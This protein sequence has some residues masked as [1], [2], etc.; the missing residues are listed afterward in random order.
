MIKIKNIALLQLFGEGE[1][2][3]GA[4]P[5]AEGTTGASPAPAAEENI[6]AEDAFK[7]FIEKYGEDAEPLKKH[8]E[9]NFSKRYKAFKETE[10]KVQRLEDF[11]KKVA[12]RYPNAK[13]D[14]LDSLEEAFIGD[15]RYYRDRAY[16]E[17]KDA[18]EMAAEAVK[19]HRNAKRDKRLEEL[20]AANQ[21]EQAKKRME[22]NAK[23]FYDRLGEEEKEL[24]K[25]FADFNLEEELK[26]PR[27]KQMLVSGGLSLEEAYTVLHHADIVKKTAEDAKAA[28][29]SSIAS[30]GT[31]VKEG[32]SAATVP[33]TSAI[34]YQNM[35]DRDF[36]KLYNSMFN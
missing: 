7:S 19:D 25:K 26:N 3:A 33:S 34:D 23:Q 10:S 13:A 32:A 5:A 16:E 15:A 8:H 35:S 6:S 30:K 24:K 22:A 28:T 31:R 29:V 18:D 4:A 21:A 12:E 36:M 9:K 27:F 2:D 14:D 17:G 11:R 1:G 20:E